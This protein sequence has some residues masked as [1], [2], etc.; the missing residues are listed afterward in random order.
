MRNIP[1]IAIALTLAATSTGAQGSRLELADGSRLWID[2]TSTLHN[3]TCRTTDLRASVELGNG[4]ASVL[5][6]GALTR[7]DVIVPVKTLRCGNAK[8]DRNMYKALKAEEFATVAYSLARY[9]MLSGATKDSVT[10]RTVGTLTIAGTP[11][12]I[13]MDVRA[14][15]GAGEIVQ[16]SG[17]IEL[18][19]TDFGIKPPVVMAG[20]L[21]TGNRITVAFD[22]RAQF[23]SPVAAAWDAA[24]AERR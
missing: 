5:G 22:L 2:G 4:A 6:V 10:I 12:E 13:T 3:W 16:G 21:K 8:M 24:V 23:T 1:S 14:L 9:E 17:R 15:R 20:L 19:M 11:R 18:L 7:A